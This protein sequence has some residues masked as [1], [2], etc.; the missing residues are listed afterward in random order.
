MWNNLFQWRAFASSLAGGLL[1]CLLLCNSAVAIELSI[2]D[3]EQVAIEGDP[4]I[5]QFQARAQ[6]AM[7]RSVADGQL[8]DPRAR[9]A[10]ANFPLSGQPFSLQQ[11]PMT[12]IIFGVQQMFP[13]AGML[14]AKSNKQLMKAEQFRARAMGRAMMV[15]RRVRQAWMDVHY[16][17]QALTLIRESQGVFDQLVKI[18][19]YQYRAGRGRQADVLNAQLELSLLKDKE[20]MF[21]QKKEAAITVLEKWTGAST[22]G[23]TFSL[24]FPALSELPAVEE[25]EANIDVHPTVAMA[26]AGLAAA[27][28]DVAIA[29]S[30]FKPSWGVDVSYG[31][32]QGFNA[33]GETPRSDFVSGMVSIDMPFFTA[34]RQDK[35]LNAAGQEV[36]AATDAIDDAKRELKRTLETGYA[37]WILLG[38]RVKFYQENVLPEARQFSES[39]RRAYQ[40]QVSEFP[41]L[42][43][44]RLTE[45]NVQLEM[46]K[47]QVERAKAH[48]DLQYIAGETG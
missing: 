45:L 48:F 18:T 22:R 6:S 13:P 43:K 42:I 3:V 36:N 14:D 31:M 15:L 29:K 26:K 21:E 23:H 41:V 1:S 27:R 44:A 17:H 12:Q 35:R 9:I 7:E 33:D 34:K 40:S 30:R 37:N 10:G 2:K 16:F 32:R 24:V 28:Q 20:L 39:S 11:E 25:L 4:Q 5:R 47:L 19:Q 38:Q 46:L 8:P